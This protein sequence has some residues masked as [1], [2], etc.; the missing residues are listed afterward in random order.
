MPACSCTTSSCKCTACA[1]SFV[2]PAEVWVDNCRGRSTVCCG[3]PLQSALSIVERDAHISVYWNCACSSTTPAHPSSDYRWK[4]YCPRVFRRL[5]AASHIDEADYMLSLAGS[6]ALRQLNSPGKSGSM[7][8]LSGKCADPCCFSHDTLRS[9]A[10]L[11]WL[12]QTYAL[13]QCVTWAAR[14]SGAKTI[15]TW[16]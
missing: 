11:Q 13:G 14:M 5:R 6:Q 3:C 8:M 15:H 16:K 9:S 7:F 2:L 10:A 12:R 4:D 1:F